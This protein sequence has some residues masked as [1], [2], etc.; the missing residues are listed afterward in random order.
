MEK[1]PAY[2]HTE[3]AWTDERLFGR[4]QELQEVDQDWQTAERRHAIQ[5][6][7]ACIVF[8]QMSRYASSHPEMA[9]AIA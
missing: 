7:L 1:Y 2:N 3:K 4:V 8:E 5:L 6:E 9:E